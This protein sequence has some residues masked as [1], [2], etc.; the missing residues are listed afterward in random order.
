MN[1][2]ANDKEFQ[3]TLKY[4]IKSKIYLKTYLIKETYIKNQHII[5]NI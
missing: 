4:G 2:L 1:I 3:N 5:M